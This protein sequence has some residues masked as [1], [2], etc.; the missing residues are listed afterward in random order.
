M[1]TLTSENMIDEL[2]DSVFGCAPGAREQYV[3]LQALRGLVRLAKVEQI[4][5]MKLSAA[6]A[7]GVE[8]SSRRET[9]TFLRQIGSACHMRHSQF[10]FDQEDSPSAE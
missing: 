9:R 8:S 4:V 6:K 7:V 2:I 1:S 5:A 3:F 10:Q